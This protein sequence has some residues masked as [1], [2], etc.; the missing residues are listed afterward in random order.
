MLFTDY[1]EQ[2]GLSGV[3]HTNGSFGESY[4]PEIVGAGTA[5]LDYDGDGWLDLLVVV[6]GNFEEEVGYSGPCLRL[7]RN[8]GDGTFTEVTQEASLQ[9]FATYAF[10]VTAGDYDNDGDT[11]VFVTTLYQDHLLQN[12]DGVFI[13]VTEQSGL[14]GPSEWSSSALFFDADND[15]W[16][17]LY[18]GTY[19][20]WSPEEDIYCGFE[21]EKVYCTPELYDGIASRYY[22]NAGD[23]TFVER[24]EEAGFL[25]G[26][27]A[28]RDK[29][30]GVA[31]FDAD[32]NGW[33][34]IAVANDT[35]RDM[36]F[37]NQGDGTFM[38]TGIRSGI[39]YDLHGIPR[40]GMGIDTGV[41]DSTGEPTWFVGNFS[42]EMVG[43]YRHTGNGL[44]MDRAASSRI[45]QP[46]MKTL[47]FG[48]V[49][50]DADLDADLDLLVVNGHV[51]THI[52]R[53]VEGITFRQ[54][55][56][57][58]L[59]DGGGLFA[60]L[61][62]QLPISTPIVGRGATYGDFDQDGDLDVVVTENDGPTHL[63]RNEAQGARWLRVRLEGRESNRDGYG[64]KVILHSGGTQQIRTVRAGSSYLSHL[65]SVATFGLGTVTAVDSVIVRWP[66][67]TVDRLRTVPAN[68][69]QRVVEGTTDAI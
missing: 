54:P 30:L 38:E 7:F 45:G 44:F 32:G 64:A 3:A 24:T 1:T 10:G 48:L 66:S 53:I 18:I 8:Q 55:A 65:E 25:S 37:M 40:A 56:Q 43:V 17:D 9:D 59:N 60:E 27:E 29:T 2:A 11:D 21:G 26:V 6:G 39:A 35:E 67:G 62:T 58:F 23:G 5:F 4:A 22:H 52:E 63:W 47:T 20:S 61:P 28:H 19:V 57:L 13:D 34:D 49:L 33:T 51:Q 46:T 12:D 16:L 36:L 15:G 68:A 69:E 31:A 41:V 50:F 42:E 14:D